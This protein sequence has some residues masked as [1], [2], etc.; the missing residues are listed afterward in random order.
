MVSRITHAV[1]QRSR[2]TCQLV[3]T[4]QHSKGQSGQ[5]SLS[6]APARVRAAGRNHAPGSRRSAPADAQQDRG[7]EERAARGRGGAGRRQ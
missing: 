2:C 7:R 5:R 3:A 1:A 4:Q 6:H